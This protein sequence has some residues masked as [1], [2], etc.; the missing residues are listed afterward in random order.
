LLD[1]YFFCLLIYS[2]VYSFK[3]RTALRF[4]RMFLSATV[5][6][7]DVDDFG[8]GGAGASASEGGEE[9]P[10]G[11]VDGAFSALRVNPR[12]DPLRPAAVEQLRG[13]NGSC[14]STQSRASTASNV[15]THRG[16]HLS[17][18][19]SAEVRRRG[20]GALH[21]LR[22]SRAPTGERAPSN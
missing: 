16:R 11:S 21:W 19:D 10:R 12:C 8:F 20:A 15:S 7:G 9:T 2:F 5:A 1:L 6:L 3:W 18:W 14:R 4:V 17:T 13:T 22:H